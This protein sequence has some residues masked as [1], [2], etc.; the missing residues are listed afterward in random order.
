MT[1]PDLENLDMTNPRSNFIHYHSL[2][3]TQISQHNKYFENPDLNMLDLSLS[4]IYFEFLYFVFNFDHV[5]LLMMV[6]FWV[7]IFV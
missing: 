4:I 3:P 2:P 7:V 5:L 1:N 6:V